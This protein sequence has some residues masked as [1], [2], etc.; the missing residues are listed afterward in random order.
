MDYSLCYQECDLRLTG[1]TDADWAG[2]L[3]ECRSTSGYAFLSS[4]GAITWSSKK[5][6]S[7]AL[8]TMEAEFIACSASVQDAVWR[9]FLQSL[10]VTMES[11]CPLTIHCD[12]QACIAYMKDLNY[13]GRTKH[14]EIK[15]IFV[16]DIVAKK[17][18]IL[19]YISTHRMVADPFTKPIPRDVFLSHVRALGLRRI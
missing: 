7:T 2:D 14:I 1:Y 3:Y 9:R 12:S 15:H 19:K 17:E 10:Q 11:L 4:N 13:H 18:V 8:S 5:Q 16:R 6:S